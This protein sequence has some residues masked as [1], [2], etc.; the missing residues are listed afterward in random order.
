MVI[1]VFG[2]KIPVSAVQFC[3]SAPY[4]FQGLMHD[5]HESFFCLYDSL[6]PSWPLICGGRFYISAP[7]APYAHSF[8]PCIR[9]GALI[10]AFIASLL[11]VTRA[12]AFHALDRKS[13]CASHFCKCAVPVIRYASRPRITHVTRPCPESRAA[14][15]QSPCALRLSCQKRFPKVIHPT[16]RSRARLPVFLT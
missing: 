14:L 5:L 9:A 6:A 3:P 10:T 2:L 8:L 1:A 15:L 11:S 7:C 16:L 13:D 12:L 4:R